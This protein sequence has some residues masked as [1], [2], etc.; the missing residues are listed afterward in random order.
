MKYWTLRRR[1]DRPSNPATQR[2]ILEIDWFLVYP[3]TVLE[4]RCK[5]SQLW[6]SWCQSI[7]G[8]DFLSVKHYKFIFKSI[9]KVPTSHSSFVTLV[10]KGMR[11]C[12]EISPLVFHLCLENS[13][14]SCFSFVLSFKCIP[15]CEDFPIN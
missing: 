9:P 5:S 15:G 1:D 7:H 14:N 4:D 3:L 8:V 10:L 2:I 6:S 11:N 13:W 12:L